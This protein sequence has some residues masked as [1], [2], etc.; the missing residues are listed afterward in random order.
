MADEE[1]VEPPEEGVVDEI[2]NAA[3]PVAVK[4]ARTKQQ[5]AKDRH[6][7]FWRRVL[8]DEVGLEIVWGLLTDAHTFETRFA[9]GPNGFPQTEATWFHAG[10]QEFGLALYHK[11]LQIDVAAVQ[12]MH[13]L[14]DPRF[15][16]AR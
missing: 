9:C 11:L 15:P 1:I 16:K 4:R 10:R 3:D 14:H 12:R 2:P 6:D 7:D 5:K 13:A 8:A